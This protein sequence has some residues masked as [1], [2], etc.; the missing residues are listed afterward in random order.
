MA[1]AAG[2]K[3]ESDRESEIFNAF[4]MPCNYEWH[5]NGYDMPTGVFVT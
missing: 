2:L 1:R 5:E 4:P 3:E